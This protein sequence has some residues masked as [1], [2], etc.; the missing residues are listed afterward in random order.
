MVD[1]PTFGSVMVVDYG[2]QIIPHAEFE[3]MKAQAESPLEQTVENAETLDYADLSKKVLEVIN[4][5]REKPKLLIKQ[6][7]RSLHSF[8]GKVLRVEG[9]DPIETS[10]GASAYMEAIEILER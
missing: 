7:E 8:D 3:E 10:E 2:A 5:V 9:R 6:L 1:H 4:K